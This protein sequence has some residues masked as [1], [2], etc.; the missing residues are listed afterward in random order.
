MK[1]TLNLI[2]IS[3]FCLAFVQTNLNAQDIHWSQFRLSPMNLSPAATA[4]FNGDVRFIGSYRNQWANF[5]ENVDFLTFSGSVDMKFRNPKMQ[6]SL[7]GG[8]II[9]NHDSAGDLGLNLT[10]IGLNGSYTH[11]LAQRHFLTLGLQASFAERRYSPNLTVD[12]QWNG[13]V[14]DASLPTREPFDEA[15]TTLADF[16]GGLNYH[17]QKPSKRNKLDVGVALFH[18]NEP[19]H[20]FYDDDQLL[21]PRRLS[22]YAL[23]TLGIGRKLDLLPMAMR[24]EQG[25]HSQT[26]LGLAGRIHLNKHVARKT[27][28]QLGLNYRF[29]ELESDAW[30]PNL[31]VHYRTLLVG[32]SYDIN[33][34][35]FVI[36]TNNRGGLELHLNYIITKV[37]LDE[38]KI[39][40]IY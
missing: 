27:A 26:L 23:A 19:E 15:S 9:F 37:R 4:I 40:P 28:V 16:S 13:D 33:V 12:N 11:Q 21:Y 24:Q 3:F 6:N 10:Q 20:S 34:S 39:C 36:N 25:P 30:I 18:I 7:F 35:E 5:D 29:N 38:A 14:F 22:L 8:G 1:N 17:Y 32:I 2:L 31:E